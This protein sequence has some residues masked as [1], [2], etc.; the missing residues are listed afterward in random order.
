M[1]KKKR[2]SRPRTGKIRFPNRKNR[3][4]AYG[5]VVTK[6][7]KEMLGINKSGLYSFDYC[8]TR[9]MTNVFRRIQIGSF[10]FASYVL[11]LEREFPLSTNGRGRC[12]G[13]TKF[14]HSKGIQIP[15]PKL[16][17]F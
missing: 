12:E 10:I 6:Q 15:Q 9:K 16:S 13:P 11:N 17:S 4:R 8:E 1:L 5:K 2:G 3:R 7:G 14:V